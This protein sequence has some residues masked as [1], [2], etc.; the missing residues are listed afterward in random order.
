MKGRLI[1]GLV[2]ALSSACRSR[3]DT[4]PPEP[5]ADPP[6]FPGIQ[7]AGTGWDGARADDW[8]SWRGP[9]QVA[10]SVAT[11]LP[12]TLDP[13]N[14]TWSLPISGRGTPVIADG[15]VYAMGY[16]GEGETIRELML[17]LDERD[18]T[19][20]WQKRFRD[21]F[22]DTVYSRYAV[23]SPTVDPETGNVYFQTTGGLL[24]GCTRDGEVLWQ[25]SL[26]EE[27]GRLTFPNG[28]TGAPLVDEDKVI[29]HIISVTWGPLGPARDRYYAFDK[30]SGECLW[31][32]TPGVTP[33]DNSFCMPYVEERGGKRVMYVTTGCGY[34]ACIDVRTGDP[35]WRFRMATGAANASVV[36]Q[37]NTL[38]AIHGGENLDASSQGRMVGLRIPEN[39]APGP[40]GPVELDG[41]AELW[42]HE[43]EAF[44]SSPALGDGRVYQTDEDGE[45]VCVNPATGEM[46]WKRKMAADQV[47][48]SPL[49][50][51]GRLW[52]PMN[53]GTLHVL[54]PTDEDA[55]VQAEVQLAGNCMAQPS[56]INGRLFIHTT[57]KLYCFGGGSKDAATSKRSLPPRGRRRPS[58]R[59]CACRSCRP[60]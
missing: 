32:S 24:F 13:E 50:A 19:I 37:D 22:S 3:S 57:Q 35:L 18:G 47:H 49:F 56:A 42:R 38:V 17:C 55:G 10:D 2:L 53:N 20:L 11:G 43:L 29:V 58:A 46:L 27:Y 28:R 33:I 8:L 7:E 14:P 51:D 30:R 9:E 41:S 15:R 39:P 40:K 5:L 36:V 1:L 45:L 31:V 12:E 59:R 52:V 21:L 48:A 6:S 60:T 4:A 44:S 16:V 25:H 26:V 23:S 34:L 54:R